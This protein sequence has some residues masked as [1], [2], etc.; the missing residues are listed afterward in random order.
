[1]PT[2]EGSPAPLL[3]YARNTSHDRGPVASAPRP[4]VGRCRWRVGPRDNMSHSSNEALYKLLPS[5]I[6]YEIQSVENSDHGFKATIR[7]AC[8]TADKWVT[9]FS[10]LSLCTWRV[11]NT[12][13]QGRH[14]LFYRKDYVSS[15]PVQ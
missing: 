6:D 4:G 1:M 10:R 14:G 13:P 11:R 9:E 7:L 3:H 12:Y 2:E 5:N 15:Q 8:E